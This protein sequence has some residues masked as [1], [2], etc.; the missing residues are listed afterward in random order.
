MRNFIISALCLGILI[1]GWSIFAVYSN[2]KINDLQI[3]L[4]GGVIA[5]VEDGRWK[6]ADASFSYFSKDWNQYRKSAAFFLN[7][8]ELNEVDCTIEKTAYYIKAFDLS[9]ASGELA[10]LNEQLFFLHYN[11]TL[12]AENIF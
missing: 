10:S 6:D 4:T 1:G 2:D 8:Q 12:S 7:T 11:E 5:A 9:N 3:Q